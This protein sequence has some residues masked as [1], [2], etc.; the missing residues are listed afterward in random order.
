MSKVITEK[1]WKAEA[2]AAMKEIPSSK[3]LPLL[4]MLFANSERSEREI[5]FQSMPGPVKFL[6]PIVGRSMYKKTYA[7]LFPNEPVPETI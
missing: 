2:A 7:A 4:G 1:E 5:F 3:L 6:W